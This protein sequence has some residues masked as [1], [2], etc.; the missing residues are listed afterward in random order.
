MHCCKK[1]NFGPVTAYELGYAPIGRP[2][3]TVYLYLLDTLLIDTGQYHMRRYV[4]QIITDASLSA[5]LLTHYHEDHSGNGALVKETC[6][7]PVYVHPY[8]GKKL[9]TGFRILPYQHLLFGNAPQ[10]DTSA[11]PGAIETRNY[12]LQPIHTPGHSKDHTVFLEK[13]NGW[14]FSGDLFIGEK[15]QFFRSDEKIEEQ[16]SSLQYIASLDFDTIFCGH[17]PIHKNGKEKLLR[18]LAFLMEFHERVGEFY[19]KGYGE[20]AI[21][22]SLR[23]KNDLPIRIFTMGNAGFSHMVRSSLQA[24]RSLSSL[25]Q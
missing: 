13:R 11:F 22:S 23:R 6:N 7:I 24:H 5:V 8:G 18:K 1:Y 25:Q 20:R 12:S 15:I 19:A 2:I 3:K 9:A 16:I 17:R 21:I 4:S 10:V 14:L